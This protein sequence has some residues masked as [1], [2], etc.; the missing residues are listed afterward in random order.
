MKQS[1]LHNSLFLYFIMTRAKNTKKK[2]S[3]EPEEYEVEKI[4]SHKVFQVGKKHVL[5]YLVKWKNYP[6][7]SNTW[8]SIE[9]LS[10]RSNAFELVDD[11]WSILGGDEARERV[12]SQIESESYSQVKDT[13]KKSKKRTKKEEKNASKEEPKAKKVKEDMYESESDSDFSESEINSKSF[14]AKSDWNDVSKVKYVR[15]SNNNKRLDA[16]VRWA[17][18]KIALY[19]TTLLA[20]KCPLKL[21]EFYEKRVTF[22][23]NKK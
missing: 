5:K 9:N 23:R 3:P 11:Y 4:K 6:A 22:D 10:N 13:Q 18:G 17:D 16:I 8:E 7:E 14:R 1:Y 21:I 2:S 19:P 20:Q 15:M 12:M